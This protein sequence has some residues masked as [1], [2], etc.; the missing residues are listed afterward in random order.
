MILAPGEVPGAG[1]VPVP[2]KEAENAGDMFFPEYLSVLEGKPRV[3]GEAEG[4][5]Q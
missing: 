2:K 1:D 4:G 5:S 3:L